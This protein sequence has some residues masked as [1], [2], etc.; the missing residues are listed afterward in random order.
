MTTC[1]NDHFHFRQTPKTY[2]SKIAAKTIF[3]IGKFENSRPYHVDLRA[4]RDKFRSLENT[5][6]DG[7]HLEKKF[8]LSRLH[9]HLVIYKIQNSD[10]FS[11][12]KIQRR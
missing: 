2:F 7:I 1:Q 4:F 11:Q 3:L 10:T 8:G 9:T 5:V 6:R 12:D